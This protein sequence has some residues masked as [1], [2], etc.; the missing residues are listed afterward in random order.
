M[1][2]AAAR[3]AALV[4][5]IEAHNYRYYVLDN[6]TIDDSAF[7][8]LLRELRGIEA[9]HP[10][11]VT[12]DSPTQR[13]GGAPRE[14]TKKVTHRVRMFSLDNAYAE[15]D[16]REF[17]RRV[18]GGL[19]AGEL[20]TF[21]VEPKLD[22]GSVEV[23]YDAGRLVEASTRGDGETGEEITQNM[24]TLRGLPLRIA[25]Q[26][27]ITLRGE[28]LLFRKDLEAINVE[29]EAEGLEPF[30]NAR[31]AA[32]G[33][34]RMLDPRDVAKRNLR[35][36][37]YQLVEG[38]A[39]HASHSE[40]L[41]WLEA[42]GLPTHRRHK[43]VD[44][45]GVTA[46]IAAIDAARTA[47]PFETD[48]ADVKVD[49]YRQQGVLGFTSK[50]PKWAIAYKFAA[51]QAATRVSEIVLQVGRTGT[52][53]PVAVLEP[54]ALAGTTVS[55]ASL[56]NADQIALLDVRVG[57]SV[58]I[59][60]AGEIIPQVVGVDKA[61]RVGNP[62]IF[63][64]PKA[65]PVCATPVVRSEGEAAT[66]CP[67]RVCRAQVKGQIF[68]FARRF[69]MDIDHL[70]VALVD[71]LVDRGIVRDVADLYSLTRAQIAA[72]ERMGEKSAQNVYE[73][74]EGS[75]KRPLSRLLCGLG[76][77][78]I[79]QVAA[80]QLAEEAHTLGELL[81][82][83]DAQ[84][85]EHVDAIHGF[86]PKMVDSIAQF[87]ID[88]EQQRLLQKLHALGVGAPQPR[89]SVAA[90]GP[91]RGMSACVTGVLSKKRED[92]HAEIRAAGGD[93]HD[94][95]KKN[96]TLLVAGEKTGKSKLDQAKKFGTRIISEKELYD[97]L[98]RDA[99]GAK[100]QI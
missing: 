1:L 92:V 61:A 52:L 83:S 53:T 26:G 65:C 42:Q 17:F 98:A 86:G 89:E 16:L 6:P 80:R 78:Q 56:H 7:D 10:E 8:A 57:D 76:I 22:G 50:F 74:I 97:L 51:E 49:E 13:V 63:E 95:V 19:A 79:G 73:S 77:P 29:R 11:L 5:E 96:T 75:R 85:R 69:A 23:V 35:V 34:L 99:D 12:P 43:V 91:L 25:H 55:R 60:K 44:S 59:Q 48:G 72:L 9:I 32:S 71:Q 31:N 84:T 70:G 20:P 46:E 36:I 66:K 40:S 27:R 90:V 81:S 39:L 47:Y 45:G 54:V 100:P 14:G 87:L 38:P 67:N 94:G 15:A 33:S 88:P 62:M 82:W 4:R 3:H 24:R 64:M 2:P 37:F 68:Y 58:I 28:V 41:A 30:A 93:I 18:L 21:C